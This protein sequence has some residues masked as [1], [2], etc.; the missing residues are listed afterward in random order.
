[1]FFNAILI[2]GL[3]AMLIGSTRI[4]GPKLSGPFMVAGALLF[5]CVV[6]GLFMEFAGRGR[7]GRRAKID[8]SFLQ[9]MLREEKACRANERRTVAQQQ[10]AVL[11]LLRQQ[12]QQT[13]E[14]IKTM[15]QMSR[16]AI[17]SQA[18]SNRDAIQSQATSNRD[19][20][21]SLE[22]ASL[23]RAYYIFE[24]LHQGARLDY[25]PKTAGYVAELKGQ[26]YRVTED[27]AEDWAE[28]APKQVNPKL[29]QSGEGE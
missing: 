13:T 15:A 3:V 14:I 4:A 29:L 8:H 20:M 9:E 10:D 1:M 28:L 7:T 19:A 5:G 26:V 6:C 17:Q 2:G 16:D 27:E 25:D 21:Q 18:A 24:L 23:E 11:E 12:S 22:R